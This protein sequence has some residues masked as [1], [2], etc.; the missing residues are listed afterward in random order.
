MFFPE[1]KNR[2]KV[3]YI[4]KIDEDL[5]KLIVTIDKHKLTI[6]R[7]IFVIPEDLYYEVVLHLQKK[8][9]EIGIECL[10]WGATRLT[11]LVNK[12][13]HIKLSLIHISEPTRP[14]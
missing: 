5:A 7:W 9:K 10:Y 12:H 6:N 8:S 2:K 14:Y 11:A 4:A 3:K 13:P 1:E